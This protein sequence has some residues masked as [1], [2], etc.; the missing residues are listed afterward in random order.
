MQRSQRWNAREPAGGSWEHE[1]HRPSPCRPVTVRMNTIFC[2]F[3]TVLGSA[4]TLNHLTTW[5]PQFR[6]S[7]MAE[8]SLN[9]VHD[10]TVNTYLNMEQSTLSFNV[11]HDLSS[12]FNWN[13]N[14][15]FVY[16][17]A[18]Y[19]DTSNKRNEVT[20]WDRIVTNKEEAVF[21]WKSLMVEYP[22]R[23]QF[24]ELRGKNI[25]LHLRYRTMP[26]TGLMYPKEVA[27]C[28][29]QAPKEHFR[30]G[31]VPLPGSGKRRNLPGSGA[32]GARPVP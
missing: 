16:V 23:D 15:L 28:S 13:M 20:I 32:E 10:L 5:L 2:S 26:I 12:E 29:F 9:K 21:S 4:A 22:L 6:A 1:V 25:N 19:N 8:V 31:T 24:R 7:P 30:D 11:S 18:S 27:S 14:Q 17:V 3:V